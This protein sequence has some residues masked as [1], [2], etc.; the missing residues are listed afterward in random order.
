MAAQ[1][2]FYVDI[3][4]L[5]GP[6]HIGRQ[7]E[8]PRPVPWSFLESDLG[9]TLRIYFGNVMLTLHYMMLMSHKPT[10][11]IAAKQMVINEV[12]D[13]SIKY[14]YSDIVLKNY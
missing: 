7:S 5:T 2:Q 8:L 13:L 6:L 4:F 11:V 12:Y 10:S 3:C 9:C 1:S 14:C